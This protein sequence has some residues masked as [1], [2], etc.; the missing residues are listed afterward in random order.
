ML[1]R[2]NS[3]FVTWQGVRRIPV[4][5]TRGVPA[6]FFLQSNQYLKHSKPC[7]SRTAINPEVADIRDAQISLLRAAAQDLASEGV[8]VF[9]LTGIFHETPATVYVDARCHMNELGNYGADIVSVIA[10]QAITNNPTSIRFVIRRGERILSACSRVGGIIHP[11]R[12]PAAGGEWVWQAALRG[13][14]AF[15]VSAGRHQA[16][17]ALRAARGALRRG[18][19]FAFRELALYTSS[20]L[21]GLHH[22]G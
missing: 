16:P 12:C 18:L 10:E 20:G 17:D 13:H 5:R 11:V 19:R 1:A 4:E 3:Y 2:S 8:P 7:R 6:C 9:D 14:A 15:G 21:R 22:L